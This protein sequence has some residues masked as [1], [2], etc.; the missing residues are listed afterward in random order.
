M[1]HE[2]AFS[3]GDGHAPALAAAGIGAFADITGSAPAAMASVT[4]APRAV[5]RRRID[6]LARHDARSGG[7]W[8]W[9]DSTT[10][11]VE[12]DGQYGDEQ[13]TLCA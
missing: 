2:P 6:D 4:T 9:V 7:L 8:R 10:A 3:I 1:E 12:G 5:A 11:G 13:T